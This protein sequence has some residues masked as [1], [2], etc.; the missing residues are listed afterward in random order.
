MVQEMDNLVEMPAANLVELSQ[1]AANPSQSQAQA[2][3]V[4]VNVQLDEVGDVNTASKLVKPS[5]EAAPHIP[6]QAQVEE[7]YC[8]CIAKYEERVIQLSGLCQ[9]VKNI[10]GIGWIDD[11]QVCNDR[12]DVCTNTERVPPEQNPAEHTEAVCCAND[13]SDVPSQELMSMN[14][15]VLDCAMPRCNSVDSGLQ[16]GKVPAAKLAVCSGKYKSSLCANVPG[17][18][19]VPSCVVPTNRRDVCVTELL[20]KLTVDEGVPGT[21]TQE[22]RGNGLDAG[23]QTHRRVRTRTRTTAW[24]MGRDNT[25]LQRVVYKLGWGCDKLS[26]NATSPNLYTSADSLQKGA[27]PMKRFGLKRQRSPAAQIIS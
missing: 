22:H 21:T 6:S 18:E 25:M 5:Q 17:C 15:D 14:V 8:Q 12:C 10:V 3:C 11:V 20:D 13:N 19:R 7:E 26:K 2:E 4:G 1:A 23:T 24:V 27:K 9:V 16:S